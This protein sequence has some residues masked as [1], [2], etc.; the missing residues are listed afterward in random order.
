MR[1]RGSIMN[2]TAQSHAHLQ[3]MLPELL[4]AV[5][6]AQAQLSAI[7]AHLEVAQTATFQSSLTPLGGGR[8][9][10]TAQFEEFGGLF[11]SGVDEVR[12]NLLPICEVL[13][14]IAEATNQLTVGVH[15]QLKVDP[16]SSMKLAI[17]SL[18][19]SLSRSTS[20]AHKLG[21]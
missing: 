20:G 3:K 17:G 13:E 5:T 11:E 2:T 7:S 15:T 10:Y 18:D 12:T 21:I 8:P 4:A 14:Q 6:K 16:I 19:A 9:R 1:T